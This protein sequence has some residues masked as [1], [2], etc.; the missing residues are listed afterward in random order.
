M[1]ILKFRNGFTIIESLISI[2]LIAVTA[3]V[4]FTIMQIQASI[5]KTVHLEKAS[6][7]ADKEIE[8]LRSLG[9]D[10]LPS[11]GAISD[12][13]LNELPGGSAARTISDYEGNPNI[14]SVH[15]DIS[16]QELNQPSTYVL[17]TL[18]AK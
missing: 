15:I 6:V 14:K 16:W 13:Q 5:G 7:I 8:R 17:D 2:A 4:F 1:Q 12:A 3:G 18:I 10:N 11:S 9:F